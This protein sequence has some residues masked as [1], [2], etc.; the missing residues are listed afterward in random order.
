MLKCKQSFTATSV[1][2]GK[3]V[4]LLRGLMALPK[5]SA[6]ERRGYS[7]TEITIS[8]VLI[9]IL[10]GIVV[11]AF[12]G[13]QDTA[14]RT[15]AI[16]EINTLLSSARAYRQSF[17]QAGTYTGITVEALSDN[18]YTIGTVTPDGVNIYGLET[19]LAPSTGAGAG[20][21]ALFTYEFPS[22][23]PCLA[24]QDLYTDGTDY[25]TGIKAHTA[26][27]DATPSVLNLTLE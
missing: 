14:N 19:T 10:V 20:S 2:G 22:Q 24:V 26:C 17:A 12:V 13:T 9:A 21:D 6:K 5:T 23:A 8:I 16:G 11:N 3:T 18:G 15:A 4:R 7:V 1:R 25:V 27:A